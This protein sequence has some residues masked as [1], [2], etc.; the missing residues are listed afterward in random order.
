MFS[1]NLWDVSLLTYEERLATA[2]RNYLLREFISARPPLH[3]VRKMLSR[4]LFFL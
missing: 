2:K 1:N 4:M 3:G